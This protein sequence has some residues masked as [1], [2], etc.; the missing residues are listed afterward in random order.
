MRTA[1]F[2]LLGIVVGGAGATAAITITGKPR[3]GQL[4]KIPVA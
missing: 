2:V 3:W 1:L 4:R